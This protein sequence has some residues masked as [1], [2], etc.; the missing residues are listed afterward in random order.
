M[1]YL[2][3]CISL[4]AL[5]SC[6]IGQQQTLAKQSGTL[7]SVINSTHTVITESQ[8]YTTN[9]LQTVYKSLFCPENLSDNDCRSNINNIASDPQSGNFNLDN[10]PISNNPM[11][12]KLLSINS[13]HYDAIVHYNGYGKFGYVGYNLSG[14]VILPNIPNNGKPKGVILYF[15]PTAFDKAGVPS[16]TY[17]NEHTK[18]DLMYASL[19]ASQGYI[20]VLPDYIGQGID[21]KNIHPYV[22]FPEP[23]VISAIQ[24]L[25]N[26]SDLIKDK[27]GINQINLFS[28]GYSEG[29]GYSIWLAKY[30]K[31]NTDD[32]QQKLN[33]DFYNFIASAGMDGAYDLYGTVKPYLLNNVQDLSGNEFNIK[34]QAI[35]NTVKPGLSLLALMSY[36]T[37]AQP[38]IRK[39]L[40]SPESMFQPDF[41]N[42]K[43]DDKK[44]QES[45]NVNG[46][47][48][49]FIEAL[50]E[51]SILDEDFVSAILQ[52]AIKKHNNNKVYLPTGDV[53]KGY[54][55]S[56]NSLTNSNVYDTNFDNAL[57][58]ASTVDFAGSTD[59]PIYIFSLSHDSV[60]SPNNMNAFKKYSNS[61]VQFV[62]LNNSQVKR[63]RII[64]YAADYVDH[65][66]GENYANIYALNFFNKCVAN[67]T[68]CK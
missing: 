61:K 35:T 39:N 49:N 15:H 20:V 11:L 40:S 43:C 67:P 2:I 62:T 50:K 10:N 34:Y 3:Y 21:Y 19:Y 27:Y 4:F 52:S 55:N 33:T 36:Y 32:Q 22:I 48:L 30:L 28:A 23:N 18:Q 42:M 46:R 66:S 31:E 60:V 9:S 53:I 41:F 5:I 65:I 8:S 58:L 57:K 54:E 1:K 45:C 44:Q 12:I 47:Q 37:Y 7:G 68:T 26:V 51:S 64:K 16:M 25:N 29:A 24:L 6:D 56:V 13:V 38:D 63:P 14:A 59:K 17:K